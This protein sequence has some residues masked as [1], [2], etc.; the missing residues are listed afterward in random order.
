MADISVIK[1]PNGNSYNLK[2]TTA[3]S[4]IADLE[5][6]YNRLD[7]IYA[8]KSSVGSP[9]MANSVSAMTD[10]TKVYVYTGS[11]SGYSNGHWYYYNGSSW[12]DGG[13]YNSV[14]VVTDPL[15]IEPNIAADAKS[16]GDKLND[17]KSALYIEGPSI[18]SVNDFAA[19]T[20]VSISV[21]STTESI[22]VSTT[23]KGTYRCAQTNDTF[24]PTNLVVGKRY[25]IHVKA[26]RISGTAPIN[27]VIR[28]VNGNANGIAVLKNINDGE[29]VYMDFT[30]DDYAKRVTLMVT[31]STSTTG[32]VKFSEIWLKEYDVS[33]IDEEARLLINKINDRDGVLDDFGKDWDRTSGSGYLRILKNRSNEFT[34]YGSV[35]GSNRYSLLSGYFDVGPSNSIDGFDSSTYTVEL[36]P[37]TKYKLIVELISGDA[38][39]TSSSGTLG[40]YF[41]TYSS[42]TAQAFIDLKSFGTSRINE[43]IFQTDSTDYRF[44]LFVREVSSVTYSGVYRIIV[45]TFKGIQT[46]L[47]SY[48]IPSGISV[49]YMMFDDTNNRPIWYTGSGWVDGSGNSISV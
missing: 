7:D 34:L 44:A 46:P 24:I 8:R 31:W 17:L 26:E 48:G 32:S 3:R 21:D 35:S 14:A 27:V 33:G 22:T 1:T 39:Q 6:L 18:I 25:R 19:N 42:T 30:P 47:T 37:N 45:Q 9:L 29:D 40:F 38:I 2:D 28:G 13:V 12:Y 15:L 43:A 4:D 10:T 20:G 23:S 41:K 49:G 36:E 5:T 11:E 16:V